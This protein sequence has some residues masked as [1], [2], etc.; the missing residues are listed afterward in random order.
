M[1]QPVPAES[2]AFSQ[3]IQSVSQLKIAFLP[4]AQKTTYSDSEVVAAKAFLVF[5]HAELEDYLEQACRMKAN[6]ALSELQTNGL[7]GITALSLMAYCGVATSRPTEIAKYQQTHKNLARDFATFAS[8]STRA[9]LSSL[10]TAVGVHSELCRKNNGIKEANLLPMVVPLGL[11]PLKIETSWLLEL[12]SFG[13]DRGAH[14]HR[15]LASVKRIDDP[16]GASKQLD[17]IIDGPPGS[18]PA[19][20]SSIQVHSLRSL[21]AYLRS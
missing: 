8:P 3:F 14:A 16:Y 15:G 17:R 5:A 6:K 2:P 19:A 20:G 11:D 12:N 1:N 21:D 10:K 7:T 9:L 18:A 4:A 13:V